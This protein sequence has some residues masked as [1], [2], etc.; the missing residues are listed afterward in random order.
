MSAQNNKI[1]DLLIEAWTKELNFALALDIEDNKNSE[2]SKNRIKRCK[3][4]ITRAK[5]LKNKK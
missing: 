1:Y 3:W 5:N 2:I 4:N